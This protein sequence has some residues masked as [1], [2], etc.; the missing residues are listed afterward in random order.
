MRKKS[1]LYF[2]VVVFIVCFFS[3][4]FYLSNFCLPKT[5]CLF[6][7]YYSSLLFILVSLLFFSLLGF[8]FIY[9]AIVD[10]NEMREGKK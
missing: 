5:G 7:P 2:N 6:A 9:K 3:Y 8:V 4:Y 10:E 1:L